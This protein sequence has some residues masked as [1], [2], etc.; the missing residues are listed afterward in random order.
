M[1]QERF[2]ELPSL[3]HKPDTKFEVLQ[4]HALAAP[5]FAVVTTDRGPTVS[6]I[7]D[8]AVLRLWTRDAG[9]R[10]GKFV[11]DVALLPLNREQ[12]GEV[13]A[14]PVFWPTSD[15]ADF[16]GTFETREEAEAEAAERAAKLAQS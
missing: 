5:A 16:H 7:R 6:E 4:V 2:E 9:E 15:D 8:V 12:I 3:N 10:S 11:E 13:L 1:D 14:D